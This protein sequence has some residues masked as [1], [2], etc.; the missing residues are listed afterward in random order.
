MRA[1]ILTDARKERKD[2]LHRLFDSSLPLYASRA[3]GFAAD[4]PIPKKI[5]KPVIGAYSAAV[6][7]DTAAVDE[8]AGGF[9]TFGDF[10]ARR[11]RSGARPV[12]QGEDAFVSPCDGALDAVFSAD[13][14]GAS[15]RVK[16][17]DYSVDELLG[18]AGEGERFA[19]GGGAVIYLHP[20][21]YHR[22]H[23]PCRADLVRVRHIPG[24]RYPVAPWSE[25]RVPRLYQ[26]NERVVFFFEMPKGRAL[27][28]TMVAAMGVGNIASPH[29]PIPARSGPTARA[30]EPRLP[31]LA[32]DELG[33]FRLGSTVV[34]LWSADAVALRADVST[35]RR[36][37]QGEALGRLEE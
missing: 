7:V 3:I 5:L 36:V 20:R 27:A 30:L 10:F 16:G 21:D 13:G 1:D 4:L 2:V 12:A 31:L 26:K 33:A 9:A 17:N 6:G 11:L 23:A 24:A 18:S 8:P 37:L 15:L 25:K 14:V 35:G 22:V 34:L 29:A 19:G 28:L 32:A